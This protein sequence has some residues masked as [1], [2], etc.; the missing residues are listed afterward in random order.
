MPYMFPQPIRPETAPYVVFD[1]LFSAEECDQVIAI[2]KENGLAAARVGGN[3]GNPD[4]LV[5]SSKRRSKVSWLEWSPTTEMLFSKLAN[6][7]ATANAK[8]WAYNLAGFKEPLQLTHY[9]STDE[10]HY[11]WHED[12][13]EEGT[14]SHRKLSCVMLLGGDFDGGKF[15]LHGRG[16]PSEMTRGTLIIFPSFKLH[17]VLPVTRGERWSLVGWVTG[18]PF[19]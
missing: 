15:E 7:V 5:D 16:S 9:E 3:S 1:K 17:R 19:A 4:G 12:H 18:P 2:A 11:D 14:M 10:G 6:A 8:W 13:S